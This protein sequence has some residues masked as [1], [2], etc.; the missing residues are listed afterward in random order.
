M[1]SHALAVLENERPES[2]TSTNINEE[3]R[4]RIYTITRETVSH[5]EIFEAPSQPKVRGTL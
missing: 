1:I 2:L 5:A 3:R 4:G